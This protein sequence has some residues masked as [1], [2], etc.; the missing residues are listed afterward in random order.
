MNLS[1]EKVTFTRIQGRETRYIQ[2]FN[3]LLAQIRAAGRIPT[4]YSAAQGRSWAWIAALKSAD[5]TIGWL[6][7]SFTITGQ[8]RVEAYLDTGDQAATKRV[9]DALYR[10]KQRV[11]AE[12]GTPLAWERLE[13]KRASRIARYWERRITDTDD[14]LAVL[15]DEAT[16]AAGRLYGSLSAAL[17]AIL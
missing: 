17:K 2:F 6:A 1:A 9:F 15:R 16:D 5:A 12:F 8:F 4:V 14:E 11:D 7:A 3:A 10:D 13:P